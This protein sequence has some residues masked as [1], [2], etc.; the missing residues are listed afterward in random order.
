MQDPFSV[1]AFIATLV[2][3]SY[4]EKELMS[5]KWSALLH[6][7]TPVINGIGSWKIR[8]MPGDT[9]SEKEWSKSENK[10]LIVTSRKFDDENYGQDIPFTNSNEIKYDSINHSSTEKTQNITE[11]IKE[12]NISKTYINWKGNI[13]MEDLPLTTNFTQP[14]WQL[15]V[16]KF[17]VTNEAHDNITVLPLSILHKLWRNAD[18]IRRIGTFDDN[19]LLFENETSIKIGLLRKELSSCKNECLHVKL[20]D[21]RKLTKGDLDTGESRGMSGGGQPILLISDKGDSGG[22]S[23]PSTMNGK[24]SLGPLIMMMT[25]LIMM[26]IMIPMMMSI[27]GGMMTFMRNMTSMIMMLAWPANG[28]SMP[29]G[30]MTK[31]RKTDEEEQQRANEFLS[32]FIE[33][34]SEKLES[35]INKYDK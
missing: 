19:N 15:P 22:G 33:E 9:E 5:R 26:C 6:P 10:P 29:Q 2:I 25:P 7:D 1:L 24:D 35:A 16:P 14:A 32:S 17:N 34:L 4:G 27:M 13:N 31:T 8:Y 12:S 28:A 18:N 21:T 20:L 30:L 23:M 11:A 3:S